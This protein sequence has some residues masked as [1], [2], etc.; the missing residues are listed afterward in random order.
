[1][2]YDDDRLDVWELLFVIGLTLLIAA[3]P[4]TLVYA[5]TI[6]ILGI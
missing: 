4:M 6:M 2:P 5:A 1:M 3:V